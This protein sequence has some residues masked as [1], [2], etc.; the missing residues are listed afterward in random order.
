MIKYRYYLLTKIKWF[1]IRNRISVM[2]EP[3]LRNRHFLGRLW[4]P[5]VPQP[6]PVKLGRL[7]LKICH[8]EPLKS[9]LLMKT[10]VDHMVFTV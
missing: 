2:R 7:R 3:V 6:I 4:P 8:F 1:K 10:F 5:E 9:Y